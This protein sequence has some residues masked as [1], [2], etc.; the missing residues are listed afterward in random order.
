MQHWPFVYNLG[1]GNPTEQDGNILFCY[2]QIA[3]ECYQYHKQRRIMITFNKMPKESIKPSFQRWKRETNENVKDEEGYDWYFAV[4]SKTKNVLGFV[5]LCGEGYPTATSLEIIY[6]FP[7]SRGKGNTIKIRDALV[8]QKNVQ[9][10]TVGYYLDDPTKLDKHFKV[11]KQSGFD[12]HYL[13]G[14]AIGNTF[15]LI[16][17]IFLHKDTEPSVYPSPWHAMPIEEYYRI[18]GKV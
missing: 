14:M 11:A 12:R 5:A 7:N 3:E 8:K 16:A 6:I 10:L 4:E 1:A 17:D 18:K 13:L 2:S 15:D 9:V